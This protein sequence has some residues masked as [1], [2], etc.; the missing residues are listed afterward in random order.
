MAVERIRKQIRCIN[1]SD[2]TMENVDL[3][4]MPIVSKK[5]R[6]GVWAH[7][8]RNGVI[9]IMGQK[10]SFYSMTDAIKLYRQK[11]PKYN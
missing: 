7:K 10:Y 3:F 4:E 11:F 5:V 1:L 6:D 9:N 2:I 8:Y